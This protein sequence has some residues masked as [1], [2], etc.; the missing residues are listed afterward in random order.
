MKLKRHHLSVIIVAA[1][2]GVAGAF[3][4][5]K[6]SDTTPAAD[7]AGPSGAIDVAAVLAASLPDLDGKPQPLNQWLG[8][9]MVI[10]F[11]APWCPPCREEIPGFIKL[12]EKYGDKGLVFI[13]VAL[14]EQG[15]VQSYVD[16]IGI[17]YPI[18]IGGPEAG[19]L[20]T[21]AGNRLGGLPY[22][23]VLDR[24]GKPVANYTGAVA[25]QKLETLIAP[26]L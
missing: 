25:E 21:S 10:N 5:K 8:K 9:V 26:L 11:W 14:D 19:Q 17:H 12:Q 6:L 22:T 15:R 20:S 2:F 23:L 4:Y 7:T 18:L 16:E 24:E 3:V 13:G 1:L